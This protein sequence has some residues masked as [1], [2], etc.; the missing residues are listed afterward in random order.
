[1]E[2][3]LG[4][5]IYAVCGTLTAAGLWFAYRSLRRRRYATGLRTASVALL[6]M[7]LAMTGVVR[8]VVNMTV[9]PIAWMGFGAVG[10]SVA[11]FFTARMLDARG[12]EDG[13]SGPTP[14]QVAAPDASTP[15]LP[16]KQ[17]SAPAPSAPA[18]GTGKEDFSDIEA[19]LK[20]HGI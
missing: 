19:I 14:E 15:A 3:M 1:M 7:G 13:G 11:L 10:L 18:G 20:K 5:M 8:F 2:D 12:V 4:M 16:A 9:N 17:R 6:P